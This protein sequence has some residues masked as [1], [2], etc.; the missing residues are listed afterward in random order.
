MERRRRPRRDPRPEA[1]QLVHL[2]EPGAPA[3]LDQ[4]SDLLPALI[5]DRLDELLAAGV[6][7]ACGPD[8][9]CVPSPSLLQLT[10]DA[11]AA[12]YEPNGVLDLLGT[13]RDATTAVARATVD[14]LTDRPADADPDQLVALATRGRGLLAHGTG[15]LTIHAIGKALGIDH[16]GDTTLALRQLLETDR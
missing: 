1:D 12:G 3:T 4:L 8:R 14:L 16:D 7:E 2:D 9:H 10:L 6:V 5:P 13:I 11:L 15:R